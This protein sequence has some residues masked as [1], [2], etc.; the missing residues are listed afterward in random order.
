MNDNLARIPNPHTP[1]ERNGAVLPW[2]RPRNSLATTAV[3]ELNA[4]LAWQRELGTSGFT[5]EPEIRAARHRV[6]RA[7]HPQDA[8]E[9]DAYEAAVVREGK[10][11][12]IV[13]LAVAI[14]LPLAALAT[15]ALAL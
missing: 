8:A 9:L 4:L 13:G 1:T 14:L 5:M 2:P 11:N 6:W 3:A 10:R 12:E 7:L 15:L